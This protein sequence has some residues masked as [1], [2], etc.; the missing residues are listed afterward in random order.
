[1][2]MKLDRSSGSELGFLASGC[3][4]DNDYQNF[5][6]PEVEKALETHDTIRLLFQLEDFSGWDNKALWHDLT[7]GLKINL[8][9]DKIAL[10]GDKE[11]EAWVAKIVKILSHGETN[12][13]PLDDQKAAWE[14]LSS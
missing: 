12:Y 13:F 7:F 1:M 2:L 11:W 9:V 14:W 10:V 4:T 6:I 8:R 3:L 5:L